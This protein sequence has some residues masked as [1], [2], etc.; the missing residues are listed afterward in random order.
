[1]QVKLNYLPNGTVTATPLAGRGS[2]DL[3]NLVDADGF[4]ELPAEK[5]EFLKG[6]VYGFIGYRSFF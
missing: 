1:L 3:A 6:E 2:G 4:L 5:K